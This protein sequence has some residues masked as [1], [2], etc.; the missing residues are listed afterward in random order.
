MSSTPNPWW[1]LRDLNGE[2]CGRFRLGS[3]N[4]WVFQLSREWRLA[5]TL[6]GL[7]AGELPEEPQVSWD[8]EPP[9]H[10]EI[11]R[12]AVESSE[13][14]VGLWPRLA[15]RSVV[16]RPET[17]LTLPAQASVDLFVSTPLWLAVESVEPK[18]VLLEVPTRQLT[19]TWF[20]ASAR[21]GELGYAA[22]TRARLVLDNQRVSPFR[23]LS[24]I[25]VR[26]HDEGALQI[27]RIN[28]PV[29]S[30][31]LFIDKDG[32]L[33]TPSLT[34]ESRRDGRPAEVRIEREP[35]PE[36]KGAEELCKARDP[37]PR[38]YLARAYNALIG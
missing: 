19:N 25:T 21:D 20:G 29:R 34:V 22:R 26:N 3:L 16:S 6:E 2:G 38:N 10:A 31:A 7:L 23:A 33:W 13:P 35:P 30:L 17:P 11:R 18:N 27:E 8:D 36:A 14:V 28:L 37:E 5:W 1:G 12:V 15:D 4:L 24:K 32:G 9:P